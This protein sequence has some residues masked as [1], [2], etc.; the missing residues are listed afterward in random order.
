MFFF[1]LLAP[2]SALE[3]NAAIVNPEDKTTKGKTVL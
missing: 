1:L 3:N 2:E